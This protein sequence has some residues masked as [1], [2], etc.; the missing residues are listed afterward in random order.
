MPAM[1]TI[2]A[3]KCFKYDIIPPTDILVQRE[4]KT[5][6]GKL[7]IAWADFFLVD[8]K[9]NKRREN[10]TNAIHGYVDMYCRLPT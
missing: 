9:S 6:G 5:V 1:T 3:K 2:Q 4:T 8:F 10:W 7:Y